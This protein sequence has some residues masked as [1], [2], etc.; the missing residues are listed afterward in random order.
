MGEAYIVGAARSPLGKRK[1]ELAGMHPVDLLGSVQ[2]GL[3]SRLGLEA[4]EIDQVI[5]GCV[6]QVGEQSFNVART[7]CLLYTSPSPRDA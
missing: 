4:S 1:G 2:S 7:A 6:S 3:V 5:G